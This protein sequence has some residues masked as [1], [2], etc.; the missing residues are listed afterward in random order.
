MNVLN[1]RLKRV[2]LSRE[3]VGLGFF[4]AGMLAFFAYAIVTLIRSGPL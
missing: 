2:R 1:I 3:A 4:Y